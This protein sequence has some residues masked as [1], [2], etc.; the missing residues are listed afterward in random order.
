MAEVAC[1]R[2]IQPLT[3]RLVP[4]PTVQEVHPFHEEG[5]ESML[6]FLVGKLLDAKFPR[7]PSLNLAFLRRFAK[8]EHLPDH[9]KREQEA[10]VASEQGASP[11]KS[12]YILISPPLPD[13]LEL[14]SLLGPYAPTPSGTTTEAVSSEGTRTLSSTVRLQSTKI[15]LQPPTSREQAEDWSRKYWPTTYNPA[16]Q[17][18]SHSPSPVTL[19]RTQSSISPH[20]G[21]YLSLAKKLAHESQQSQRGRPV[22]A[23]VVD[24]TLLESNR[25]DPLSAIVGVAGDSR[26][27]HNPNHVPPGQPTNPSPHSYSPD[28]EGQPSDH[29]LMRVISLI[30]HKRLAATAAATATSPP[31]DQ[32][33]VPP[34]PFQPPTPPLSPLE[35]HF[36]HLDNL[37]S[38]SGGGYLCTSLDVYITHEPCLCCAMG[39]LL[40]RF[41]TIIVG[42]R[43]RGSEF[44][45]LDAEKGYGLHWRRELNWRAIG[46][47]FFEEGEAADEDNG[48]GEESGHGL[49]F[50][51]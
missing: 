7:D 2:D 42:K 12:I 14:E 38:P 34:D 32:P 3:G 39:M 33:L 9:L 11:A 25:D 30:S 44:G 19:S 26:R 35:S 49:H 40:S 43:V 8:P 5:E 17:P 16:A 45:S 41:R 27:Y 28:F 37:A 15:P 4:L 50:H 29:A 22:G 46:F 36:F 1:L 18:S 23:V 47:E 51:P 20:A 10:D 21:L 13:R 6:V 48:D 24:P 31:T